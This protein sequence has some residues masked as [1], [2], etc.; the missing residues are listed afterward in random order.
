[1]NF[2]RHAISRPPTPSSCFIRVFLFIVAGAL[3]SASGESAPSSE[4]P[5]WGGPKGNFT[6]D[7]RGLANSW[8]SSGPKKLWSRDLGDGYSAIAVSGGKLYT[9]YR[10]ITRFWQ[11]GKVD[12]DVV[13]AIDADSG[14]TMWEYRNPAP[15]APKMQMENGPGPHATPLVVGNRVYT[16]GVMGVLHCLDTQSGKVIW[17]HDL[18]KEYSAPVRGRGYSSSPIAHKNTVILPV[19]GPGQAVIAFNQKDGSVAWKKQDLDWGPSTPLVIN[20]DGQDQLVFFGADTVAGLDP[21]N[22]DLLWSH[23]HRT[24]WG[25]NISTPMWSEGNLLFCSSAYNGGSRVLQLDRMGGKTSVKQLWFNNRMRVHIG[26][27]IRLGEYVLGSSGDFG[28]AFLTAINIKTGEIAWQDRSF[29]KASFVY[30]DGKLIIIDED[31]NLA[32]ATASPQGLK[33]HSKVGLLNSN[34]WT[35]PSLVGTRLY[36]RDRKIIMALDLS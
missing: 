5:Q 12:N 7:S 20:L 28:P 11:I 16:V 27:V 22:G 35:V 24:Q 32:L 10:E 18:Y 36:V 31:G 1:M 15:F 6:T 33:I 26:N 29:A 14:K 8:P 17:S 9:M 23:P 25:L 13:I 3:L 4:W 19:G 34:A 21:N 2:R 30:A